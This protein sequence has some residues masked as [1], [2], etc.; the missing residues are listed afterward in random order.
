MQFP[1]PL[2][3]D[4]AGAGGAQEQSSCTGP[5]PMTSPQGS[6]PAL[7]PTPFTKCCL[8]HSPEELLGSVLGQMV[9]CAGCQAGHGWD[10]RLVQECTAGLE[11]SFCSTRSVRWCWEW[12]VTLQLGETASRGLFA[13][14]HPTAGDGDFPRC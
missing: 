2:C 5:L 12:L 7:P 10:R 4:P 1:H 11:I 6:H 8:N 13:P 3:G 9:N 14:L